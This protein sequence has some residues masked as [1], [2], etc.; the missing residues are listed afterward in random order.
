MKIRW[1]VQAVEKLEY[2]VDF[3]AKDNPKA[4]LKWAK[5]IQRSVEKLERFPA[6]GRKVPEINRFEIRELI[7]GEYRI[8]YRLGIDL[9][10]ILTIYHSKQI[11]KKEEILRAKN[12]RKN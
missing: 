12:L 3:I 7:E 2:F 6:L 1:T 5:K 11:L 9:I 8:I 10:Y 4:A